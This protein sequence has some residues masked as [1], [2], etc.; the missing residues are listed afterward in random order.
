MILY[1]DRNRTQKTNALNYEHLAIDRCFRTSYC[2]NT[3]MS[4]L[5]TLVKENEDAF[6]RTPDYV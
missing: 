3:I 5:L 1:E 6:R 2:F 4:S